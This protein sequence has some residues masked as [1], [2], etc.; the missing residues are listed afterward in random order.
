MVADWKPSVTSVAQFMSSRLRDVCQLLVAT[1]SFGA[2]KWLLS[3]AGQMTKWSG[4]VFFLGFLIALPSTAWCALDTSNA[5]GPS[6]SSSEFS[7]QLVDSPNCIIAGSDGL[8]LAGC[9]QPGG[10]W[11]DDGTGRVFNADDMCITVSTANKVILAEC[12]GKALQP[13]QRWTFVGREIRS[14]IDDSCLT[15]ETRKVGAGFLLAECNRN[16]L[17]R[18]RWFM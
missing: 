17:N 5:T 4:A 3:F 1:Q 10:L 6:A 16:N 7:L 13:S 15:A 12:E 18:Q 14:Q 9:D 2:E 8:T 11:Q